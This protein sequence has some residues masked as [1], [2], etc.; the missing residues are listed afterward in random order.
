MTK[1]TTG[2]AAGQPGQAPA[3]PPQ[4]TPTVPERSSARKPSPA[5]MAVMKNLRAG[6]AP[7]THLRS[8]SEFGGYTATRASLHRNGWID[9]GGFLTDAGLAA[10]AKVEGSTS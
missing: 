7:T 1:T 4:L 2:P 3:M 9:D 6:R 8:M 5:Q 10:I